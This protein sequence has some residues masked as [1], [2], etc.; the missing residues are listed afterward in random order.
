MF[1]FSQ[2]LY[3]NLQYYVDTAF[4]VDKNKILS[5]YL[6]KSYKLHVTCRLKLCCTTLGHTWTNNVWPG[7]ISEFIVEQLTC[8]HGI[9]LKAVPR[10][11]APVSEA[12]VTPRTSRPRLR[13]PPNGVNDSPDVARSRRTHVTSWHLCFKFSTPASGSTKLSHR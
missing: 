8:K 5:I 3:E 11:P 2:D 6:S 13:W 7:W 12:W 10:V 4:P 1:C 9:K